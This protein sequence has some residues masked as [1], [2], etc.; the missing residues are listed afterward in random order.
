MDYV[1]RA[2]QRNPTS[3]DYHSNLG[4]FYFSLGNL[5]DALL[6]LERALALRG[7]HPE[8]TFNLGNTLQALGQFQRAGECWRRYIRQRPLDPN[9]HNNLGNSLRAL[10]RPQEALPHYQEALRLEAGHV[11]ALVN[12]GAALAELWRH[13]EAIPCYERALALRPSLPEAENNLANALQSLGRWEEA[14][15]H[16]QAALRMRP[17]Y[18]EAHNNLGALYQAMGRA[19]EARAC[20]EEALRQKPDFWEARGN[21]GNLLQEER[22]YGEAIEVYREILRLVPDSVE[23]HN[24]LGNS[25][26]E[27]GRYE[28]AMACYREAL[29]LRPAYFPAHANMGNT[30]R[31]QGCYAEAQ[32]CYERSLAMEPRFVEALNNFGVLLHDMGRFEDAIA[33]F[34]QALAIRPAYPDAFINLANVYREHGRLEPA[35]EA[36]DRAI[37]LRPNHPFAWNNR[38]A[39]LIEQGRIEESIASY[40][41]ALELAPDYHLAYSNLLLNLHYASSSTPDDLYREHRRFDQL[42]GAPLTRAAAPHVVSHDPDRPLRIG[43]VSA[44]FRQHSVAFFLEPILAAHRRPE[45]TVFCYADLVRPDRITHRLE[46]MIGPGWRYV[47]GLLDDQ[48]AA[49]IRADSID[50]LVDCGGHTSGNRLMTFARKPAPVQVTALGYPDTT[51]LEAVDYRL[52][53]AHADPPGP[54]DHWHSEQ[55]VRLPVGWCYRPP[56]E[57]PPVSPLPSLAGQPFTFGSFNSLAKLSPTLLALWAEI[58]RRTPASRLLI[59][60]RGLSEEPTRER[61]RARF[62]AEGIPAERL[63]LTGMIPDPAGHL[64]AYHQVDL[65]LDTFPYHGTT[66]TCEA[67]WMGLP[68]ISLLGPAHVSRVAASLLSAVGLERFLAATPEQYVDLAVAV[69]G[70][71]REL[72]AL[73]TGLREAVRSSP[74]TDA[75]AYTQSLE[76]AYRRMWRRWCGGE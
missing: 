24:N 23:T 8:A 71:P 18:P 59:K 44:D 26:Q 49:L 39:C 28:D 68:V 45:F 55:L 57:A 35:V 36:L 74:L 50:I 54:A 9:G 32:A 47:R 40:H 66:T 61:L 62:A 76:E 14:L 53:D 51:G 65:A 15:A 52:T 69:A 60:N 42:H 63:W 2:I 46:A 19:K 72:A 67:L 17:L 12:C 7:D 21:I 27:L 3:P 4:Q 6:A 75:A 48:L 25:L 56:E 30:L 34:E 1:R 58:L 13:K 11:D 38:G 41:R 70:Q 10:R 22:R 33:R 73:R 43:Y 29:R 37:E 16:Y 5:Q 20:F 31:R 64:A